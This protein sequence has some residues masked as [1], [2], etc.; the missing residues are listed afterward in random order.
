MDKILLIIQREYLTRVRKKSFLI[1]TLVGPLLMAAIMVVPIWLA[2][3][4]DDESKTFI[5]IDEGNLMNGK[6]SNTDKISYLFVNN[7]ENEGKEAINQQKF[8]GLLIIPKMDIQNPAP[9]KLYTQKNIGI[10]LKSSLKR[11]IENVLE[12]MRLEASNIDKE[13]L[14]SLKVS[15]QFDTFT[16]S[17]NSVKSSSSEAATI[18]SFIG[19]FMIYMFIFMYG[20]QVLRGVMEEK[21]NRIVEVMISSVKPFQLMMG[22]IL[23][24]SAVGL[25]QFLL[26][27]VLTASITGVISN[28]F[29]IDRFNSEQFTETL[30]TTPDVKQAMEMN[31]IVT[32]IDSIDFKMI[33]GGFLFY[34]LGGYLLYGALFAAIGSA[35][36]SETDT[37]QFMLPITIPLILSF[38]VAQNIMKAPDSTM[39]FW[40]SIIPFTSPISMMIRI[41]FGVPAWELA[42]SMGLLILGFIGTTWLAARIYRVGILMYGK[43]VSYKELSKWL[44]YKI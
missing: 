43:K 40:F 4:N 2:T 28:Y 17:E 9:V 36:D 44:F 41:P 1:M 6:L 8:D 39:A 22:K 14:K 37:Q 10:E 27:I 25:T 7:S 42:L 34:F 5:V 31:K 24:I 32:A 21:T 29:K 3:M 38:V 23:G 18:I 19:G 15:I 12:E 26:W 33:I 13:L 35:V 16:L 11:K 20:V 30:K